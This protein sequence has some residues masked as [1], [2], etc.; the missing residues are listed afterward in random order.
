MLQQLRVVQVAYATTDVRAAAREWHERYGAGPF[1]V[2]DHVPMSHVTVDGEEAV[3][4]HSCALGQW[5]NVMVEL[6]HHH[7]LAPPALEEDMRRNGTGIHHVACFVDDLEQARD[8]LVAAGARVVM[9]AQSQEV[10]FIFLDPGPDHGHL[11]EIYEETPYM[12]RL[13]GKVRD[14][15]VGWDGSDVIR[16]RR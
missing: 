6:V 9:D 16:E 12:S 1:F 8:Q 3:F 4:D 14:A 5:G 2:R 7:D 15:A 13:Y 11:V 10:R